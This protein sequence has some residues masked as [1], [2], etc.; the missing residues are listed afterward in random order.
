M[1]FDVSKAGTFHGS[2]FT[3]YEFFNPVKLPV[4]IA[5]NKGNCVTRGFG[6]ACPADA[7]NVVFGEGRD[8]EIDDVRDAGDIDSSGGDIG[9]NHNAVFSAF[10]AIHCVLSLALVSA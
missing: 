4:L 8:I 3:S 9:C 1:R 2:K 10:E 5:G 7:M 6:P